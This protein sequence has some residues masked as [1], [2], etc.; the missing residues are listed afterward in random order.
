MTFNLTQ[1]V[2]IAIDVAFAIEYLHHHL[3]TI[4]FHGD[5]KPSNILLDQDI[6]AH[7]DDL[8]L[9]KFLFGYE[10]GTAAETVSSSIEIKGTVGY[11]APDLVGGRCLVVA[12]RCSVV[13]LVS[14]VS[15]H[16]P[17]FV[18]ISKL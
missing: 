11:V 5:L 6:V 4:N 13:L 12:A 18:E 16:L 3:S 1:R 17:L 14:L 9:V 8:G 2:N 7:V 10:S 15:L